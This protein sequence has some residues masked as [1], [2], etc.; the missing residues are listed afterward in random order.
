[1]NTVWRS[2]WRE[3]RPTEAPPVGRL[4]RLLVGVFATVALVEGIVRPDLAWRP[5]VTVL[6]MALMPVLAWRRSRPLVAAL[7][8]WGLVGVLVI[9]QLTADTGDLG[10]NSM[11]VVLILLFSLVRW[12]SGRE[13]VLGVGFV[14]GVVALGMYAAPACRPR[15]SA[16]SP[17]WG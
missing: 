5:V 12:G 8:G 14:A 4:D 7:V 10:L 17:C 1:M 15:S 16:G 11:M 13:I 2:L 9:L 3:P 6:A